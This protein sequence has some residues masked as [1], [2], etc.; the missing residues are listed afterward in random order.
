MYT[1]Y[2]IYIVAWLDYKQIE[3]QSE[4]IKMTIKAASG[5]L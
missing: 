4:S 5:G 2:W 3:P 1:L